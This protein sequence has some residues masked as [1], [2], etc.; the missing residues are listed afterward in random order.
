MSLCGDQS[1]YLFQVALHDLPFERNSWVTGT[2]TPIIF[3]PTH[4]ILSSSLAR[5]MRATLSVSARKMVRMQNPQG[6][7]SHVIRIAFSDSCLPPYH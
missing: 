7:D 2:I 1:R 6:Q 4:A 5:E 3:P